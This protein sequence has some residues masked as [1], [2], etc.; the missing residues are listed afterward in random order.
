MSDLWRRSFFGVCRGSVS[1]SSV[2]CVAAV[3]STFAGEASAP[4][5]RCP[6]VK[7]VFATGVSS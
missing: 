6:A 5:I 4:V 1:V 7:M 2:V 3:F